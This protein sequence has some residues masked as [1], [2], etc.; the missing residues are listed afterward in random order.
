MIGG[1]AG[2]IGAAATNNNP[3]AGLLGGLAGGAII[4]GIVGAVQDSRDRKEQDRLAQERA[5]QQELARKRAE[6]ARRKN[7]EA[8]ELAVAQ[9]FRISDIE[10][11]DAQKKLDVANDRLKKLREERQAALQKKKSLDEAHDK[12]LSTEAEIARLEEE[13]ARLKGD[14][15]AAASA[16]TTASTTSPKAGGLST[17][18][19]GNTKP[20]N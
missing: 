7:E 15:A 18:V 16:A 6:D 17:P 19:S 3:A 2:A 10:L 11:N 20:G 1:T 9:G 8:E 14:D 5:Y 12:L 13:L 4:G